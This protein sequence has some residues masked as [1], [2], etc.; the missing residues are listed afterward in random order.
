MT[1]TSDYDV[2]WRDVYGDMQD[3]GPTHRHMRRIVESIVR[4]I[5][6]ETILDVGCG[7]GHNFDQLMKDKQISRLTGADISQD[8]LN[9]AQSRFNGDFH[10]LD[11]TRDKLDGQWDL[12][13]TSLLLE[14]V[15]DDISALKNMRAM[16]GKYLLLTT[17][18]GNFER[19]RKW[20]EQ[21]GHVRNY[22]AG[23]LEQKLAQC[24]YTVE[25]S[26]YW[27]FPFFTPIARTLQNY[28]TSRSSFSRMA[29]LQAE[30][31]YYLYFLNSWKRGDLLIILA[32]V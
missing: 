26:I 4:D 32:R 12:V 2:I 18:A 10:K 8:A 1:A 22:Q 27:G 28:R 5:D 16:T 7:A 30:I 31:M 6:Y 17:I 14:H 25:R 11:I 3:Y 21:M 24:G 9:V 29:R 15:E 23:E 19:Y 20:D 13:F